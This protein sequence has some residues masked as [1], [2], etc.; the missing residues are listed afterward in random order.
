MF[1]GSIV[2]VTNWFKVS[3]RYQITTEQY[4]E[5][6]GPLIMD[7]RRVRWLSGTVLALLLLTGILLSVLWWISRFLISLKFRRYRASWLRISRFIIV[8]KRFWSCL[9]LG[10][11]LF[12]CIR[13]QNRLMVQKQSITPWSDYSSYL[14][15]KRSPDT[16]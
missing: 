10:S 8:R 7:I 16:S 14:S 12:L 11:R 1:I 9:T 15:Q 5:V 3:L 13:M 2:S 4:S 6:Q